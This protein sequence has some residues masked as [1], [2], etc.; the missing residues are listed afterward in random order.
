MKKLL[1][2]ILVFSITPLCSAMHWTIGSSS[3]WSGTPAIIT[4]A[5]PN[6]NAVTAEGLGDPRVCM[7][8]TFKILPGMSLKLDKVAIWQ[9]GSP[10]TQNPYTLRLVDL[11]TTDP[12]F[13]GGGSQTYP[14]GTD[15]W[16]SAMTF[17]F[18]VTTSKSALEFDFENEEELMLTTGHFYAFEITAPTS[19]GGIY[20]Y[21]ASLAGSSYTNGAM[22]VDTTT[23]TP[24]TRDQLYK[25]TN[26]CDLAMAVYL[27]P[28]PATLILFA[29]GGWV[30]LNRKK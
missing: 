23:T 11:G 2:T 18:D 20:W 28:E 9:D 12:T 3:G 7:A 19:I 5:D 10:P 17:T 21:R 30:A 1:I 24:G 4:I 16:G 27:V 14:A 15:L 25:G 8:Q 22:F 26:G 29:I 13:Q 6:K